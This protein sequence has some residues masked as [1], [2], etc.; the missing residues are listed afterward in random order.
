VSAADWLGPD[1]RVA[2]YY[3][4]EQD[5][6]LWARGIAWLGRDPASG[7]EVPQPDVPG[8][9]GI[10]LDA[11]G[12]GFHATLRPPMRLR[13]GVTPA[14]F[15]GVVA[16]FARSI[17][18]FLL[19]PLEV[20]DLAG[21][22]ALHEAAPSPALQAL[23]D[24]CVARVDH[25]REPPTEAELAYRRR[26]RLSAAEDANLIRWGYPYVFSTWFF[27]MTLTRRLTAQEQA[28]YR[29]AAEAWFAPVLAGPRRV[30]TIAVFVQA[31]AGEPFFLAERVALGR[32]T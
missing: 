16:A 32:E 23:C 10:T 1:S 17:A 24:A 30:E 12:Y 31:A 14:D 3:A 11:A 22:L 9:A 8:L 21:F 2:L 15:F 27:H 5:D 7:A 25:L 26:Q 19:P 18:P 20:V 4:P 29:P 6:P 28:A 13:P